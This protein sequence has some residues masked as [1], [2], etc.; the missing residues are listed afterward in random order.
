MPMA[1]MRIQKLIPSSWAAPPMTLLL[2]ACSEADWTRVIGNLNYGPELLIRPGPR[3]YDVAA[4]LGAVLG[5]ILLSAWY[6][7]HYSAST[8]TAAAEWG[9]WILPFIGL[10]FALLVLSRLARRGASGAG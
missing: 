5:L 9:A 2:I 8:P 1:R 3:V 10:Q 6:L 4:W 7:G